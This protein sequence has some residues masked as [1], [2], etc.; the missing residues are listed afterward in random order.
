MDF[1]SRVGGK[2]K[3]KDFNEL[4]TSTVNTKFSKIPFVEQNPAAR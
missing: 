2:K 3:E 4:T 1:L